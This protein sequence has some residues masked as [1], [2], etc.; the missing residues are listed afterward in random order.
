M[1]K[2]NRS[3]LMPYSAEFM[4]RVVNDVAAYPEFLPWC[5]GVEIHHQDD[6][7]M[8]ASILIKKTVLNHWFKTS[9][10]MQPGESIEM[11]L[12]EGPFSQLEGRWQFTSLDDS[13]C[14]IELKLNFE[15]SRGVASAIIAPVFSQIANTMVDS[16]CARAQDIYE[17]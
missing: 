11:N 7:S 5:G 12:I 6:H 16:F 15:M 9:N 14:K 17:P 3:A 2:I 13:G 4:Y 8:Q 10:T 1:P